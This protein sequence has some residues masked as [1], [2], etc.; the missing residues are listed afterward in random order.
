MQYFYRTKEMSNEMAGEAYSSANGSWVTGE[1]LIFGEIT[2]PAGTKSNSH[3]H[4]NEQFVIVIKGSSRSKIEGQ[5]KDLRAGDISLKPPNSIHSGEVIG[6]EDLVFVTAK[7]TAW[8]IQG[9][10]SDVEKSEEGKMKEDFQYFY[11]INEMKD[12]LAGPSYSSSNGSWITGERV[13]FGQFCM[14]VGTKAEA[15][16]HPNEQFVICMQGSAKMEIEGN[17]HTMIPGDIAHI[18]PN[19]VHSGEIIGDVDY[20]FI[21]AKDTSHGIEGTKI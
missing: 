13:I 10:P 7:D 11:N 6:D 1:R 19:A 17:V 12:E 4:P 14:P 15:H 20:I 16:S 21:T 5:S 18:P 3:S 2:M 8:G 9:T